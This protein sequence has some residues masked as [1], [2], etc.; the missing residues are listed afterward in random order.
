MSIITLVNPPLTTRTLSL[1]LNLWMK[2][3]L[4]DKDPL[5]R[6]LPGKLL[7]VCRIAPL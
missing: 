7:H 4:L 2:V 3:G 6:T 5:G 1:Y